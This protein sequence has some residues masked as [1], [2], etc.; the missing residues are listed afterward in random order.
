LA[1]TIK[2]TVITLDLVLPDMSGGSA[3]S[4]QGRSRDGAIP[5]IMLSVLDA[6]R[7]GMELG[8]SEYLTKP[9]ELTQ[10]TAVLNGSSTSPRRDPF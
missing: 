2:P 9:I 6:K 7:T 5:V 10:L 4:A 8:A 3:D 1:R